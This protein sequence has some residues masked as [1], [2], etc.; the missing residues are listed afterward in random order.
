MC[1]VLLDEKGREWIM[2]EDG[3]MLLE[4]GGQWLPR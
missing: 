2:T 3:L 1:Q 4:A